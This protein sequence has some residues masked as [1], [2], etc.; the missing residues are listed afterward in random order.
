MTSFDCASI[1]THVHT[2]CRS[3]AIPII[4]IDEFDKLR[5][6][7]ARELTAH[8]IKSLYDNAATVNATIILVGV[9]EDVRE[10]VNDHQSLKRAL[11]EVKMERMKSRELTRCWTSGCA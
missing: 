11:T 6:Q 4:I 8:I 2:K 5:D 3:N 1:A 10:L 7:S 9:A